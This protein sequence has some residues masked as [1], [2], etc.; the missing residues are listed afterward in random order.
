MSDT[1]LRIPRSAT[2]EA[3]P[4]RW[5]LIALVTLGLAV[6][7]FAPESALALERGA[8]AQTEYLFNT[9]KIHHLFCKTC[10]IQSFSRATGPD[11]T[12]MVAVNV[13]AL[14]GVEPRE[15]AARAHAVDGRSR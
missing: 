2:T 7:V 12:P 14:E 8:E 3:A 9:G 15:L 10:G 11:G 1:T 13:N 5:A 6:L 4:V